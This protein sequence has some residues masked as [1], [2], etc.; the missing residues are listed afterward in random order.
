MRW[1]SVWIC[2]GVSKKLLI[3]SLSNM[4]FGMEEDM[5]IAVTYEDGNVFA[6][7]GRTEQF[8]I[9]DIT[10]GKVADAQVVGT[11]GN[12]HGAL[13]GM[14]TEWNVDTL[15]CGGIGAG[16][17][18]ALMEAGIR[19]YGGVSGSADEAVDALLSGTL[20]YDANVHCDHSRHGHHDEEHYC[21]V[22][23]HGCPGSERF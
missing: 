21:G 13:A 20:A 7:F 3:V 17:Q 8:K 4:H 5:K 18:S 15:I 9:Y 2:A 12:G 11:D 23:T 1:Y 19:F 10:G 6:H 22:D 16:A 14:L